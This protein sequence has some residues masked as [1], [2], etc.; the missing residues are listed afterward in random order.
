MSSV[1]LKRVWTD[2]MEDT[3]DVKELIMFDREK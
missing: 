3:E 2:M 1:S